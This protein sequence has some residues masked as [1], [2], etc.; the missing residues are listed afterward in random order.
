M[1][2]SLRRPHSRAVL[3]D[4]RG[5]P[6]VSA[7][8]RRR[9]VRASYDVAKTG[10]ENKRHWEAADS[11]SADAANS[12]R[13]RQVLRN[14]SRYEFSNNS[15]IQGMVLTLANDCIGTGP[16][17][18][19]TG[20]GVD[21]DS[22]LRE[23]RRF[24]EAEFEAY[25]RNIGLAEKL[26]TMRQAKCRDG[27]AFAI[28]RENSQL[29][30]AVKIDL[31]L[32]E[33]EMC[34][35]TNPWSFDDSAID[36]I[37]FDRYGNPESYDILPY[38]P[39]G[40]GL[41]AVQRDAIRVPARRVSHWFRVDRPG[42]HR[43]I[44]EIMPALPLCALL[45]R[46]TLASVTAAEAAADFSAVLYSDQPPQDPDDDLTSDSA[47]ETLEIER[48]MMMTLPAGWKMAQM[49][50]E[51][52]GATYRE[53]KAELVNEIARCLN[54]PYN[55]AAANSSNYNYASGRLDWQT[56]R[57]AQRVERHTVECGLLDWLFA[58]WVGEA[59][60]IEGYLPQRMRTVTT[61]WGH[62]W[63]WDGVEHVDPAKEANAQK[64]R[65]ENNTT[66]LAE[67]Y[68]RKG[69]D[70]EEQIRQRARERELMREVGLETAPAQEGIAQPS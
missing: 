19:L 29:M 58:K 35:S 61:D 8:S 21:A 2:M 39:G 64:T 65:L 46:W 7:E 47:F 10:E 31:Q 26:R 62:Q 30:S 6:V 5:N 17:L 32:I 36:G 4:H 22:E 23:A 3:L 60:K 20:R 68:A 51:H 34:A 18:Q 12:P 13:V 53:V 24:V 44:P 41:L 37:R 42:Q 49:K 11:L 45:R 59:I 14:R 52:P 50:A 69:Q 63:M 67:E 48:S 25:C 54:M 56:Y 55:I 66:T 28:E 9:H 70:W 1:A 27:E 43:G 38:H 40:T 57:S 15:L 16:R 33:A